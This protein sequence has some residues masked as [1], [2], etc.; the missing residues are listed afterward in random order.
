MI[1]VMTAIGLGIVRKTAA[2]TVPQPMG[3]AAVEESSDVDVDSIW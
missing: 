3:D 2:P 1:A